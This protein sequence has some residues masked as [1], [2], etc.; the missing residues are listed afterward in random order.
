[1]HFTSFPVF[2][3]RT[4]DICIGYSTN[5]LGSKVKL[6]NRAAFDWNSVVY[7]YSRCQLSFAEDKLVAI[8]GIAKKAAEHKVSIAYVGGLWADDTLLAQLQWKSVWVMRKRYRTYVGKKF[9]VES[10]TK[11]IR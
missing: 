4:S 6:L 8:S 7:R 3:C 1:M 11:T 9:D 2:E 10:I 5:V